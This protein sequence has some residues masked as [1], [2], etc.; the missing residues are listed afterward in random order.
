MVVSVV[1]ITFN[2]ELY[3][4]E[5]IESILLQ[6]TNF[7]LELIIANDCSTDDT[8][9]IISDIKLNHP[10]ANLIKYY[11]QQFN[12][13]M[14]PNFVF[15][16]KQVKGKFIALCDGDDYWTD[17]LKL[18]KQVDFLEANEEYS[19]CFHK[20]KILENDLEVDDIVIEQRY[21]MIEDKHRI[22]SLDIIKHSNFIHTCSFV[23]RKSLFK[24]SNITL[25]SPVGDVLL[26]TD[27][28]RKGYLKRFDEYSAVYRRGV[29]IYSTLDATIMHKKQLQYSVC[30]LAESSDE[31]EKLLLVNKIYEKIDLFERIVSSTSYSK[32]KNDIGIKEA[33]NLFFKAI[34]NRLAR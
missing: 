17:P 27:I 20:V 18:Q 24:I 23:F 28:A 30:L 12:I 26:F 34:K 25:M 1:M 29:G 16:L 5:A 10:K 8:D 14:M 6:K 32:S 2:H 31:K 13:G 22:T 33:I 4:R 7:E 19:G 21:E 11:R 15:A 9:N 3:I